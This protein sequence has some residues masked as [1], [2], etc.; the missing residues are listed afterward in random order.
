MHQ[1][2]AQQ[3]RISRRRGAPGTARDAAHQYSW[4]LEPRHVD[5]SVS[6]RCRQSLPP[7][8]RR[9]VLGSNRRL[10]ASCWLPAARVQRGQLC[11]R[12][13]AHSAVAMR[14]QGAGITRSRPGPL[15]LRACQAQAANAR[16]AADSRTAAVSQTQVL[17]PQRECSRS[18]VSSVKEAVGDQCFH[19]HTAPSYGLLLTHVPHI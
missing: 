14:G 15:L 6:G 9:K 3:G 4:S 17:T 7:N 8:T 16:A 11:Q 10:T 2:T 19:C 13:G 12:D 5:T 18:T 1:H